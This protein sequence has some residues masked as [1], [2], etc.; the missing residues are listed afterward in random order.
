MSDAGLAPLVK[1]ANNLYVT[2]PF[3]T[4]VVE[5]H[6][7]QIGDQGDCGFLL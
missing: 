2:M 1:A 5:P 3:D 4:S 7:S 6:P